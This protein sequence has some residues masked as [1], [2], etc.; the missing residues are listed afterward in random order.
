[1]RPSWRKPR[2]ASQEAAQVLQARENALSELTEDVARLAARHQ[3]AQ[4]LLEDSRK[5]EA[6]SSE[7][8]EKAKRAAGEAQALLEKAAVDFE[9]AEQAESAATKRSQDAEEA[10]TLPRRRGRPRNPARRMRGQS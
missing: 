6:R 7:E 1:M 3:S 8:A 5:T 2:K 10:L 9:A 4:R